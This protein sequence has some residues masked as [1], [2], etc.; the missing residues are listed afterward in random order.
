[1]SSY[2]DDYREKQELSASTR[3][4]RIIAI[5]VIVATLPFYCVGVVAY[6]LAPT[7]PLNP[8]TPTPTVTVTT[9]PTED[10][11]IQVTNTLRPTATLL[12]TLVP[13]Q[14]QLGIPATPV[15]LFTATTAPTNTPAFTA[16]P[17]PT[18]TPVNT[19]V[20]TNTEVPPITDTPIPF[21][22]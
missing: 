1:M 2:L 10:N 6:V 13:T 3:R 18:N 8:P 20:P 21:S 15:P 11:V 12:P 5:G 22:N 4:N 14:P 19:A 16:T 17:V 9:A 7:N